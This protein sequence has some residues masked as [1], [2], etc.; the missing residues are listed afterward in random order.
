MSQVLGKPQL[1]DEDDDE[2]DELVGLADYG[3][4]PDSS[5][6]EP[7]SGAE[8]GGERQVPCLA[9]SSARPQPAS[10]PFP[11]FLPA[12]GRAERVG[13]GLGRDPGVRSCGVGVG[14]GAGA[15]TASCKMG[16]PGCS[17]DGVPGS[18][19]RAQRGNLVW[20]N[21]RSLAGYLP[22]PLIRVLGRIWGLRR[23][24]V[25][26]GSPWDRSLKAA[27]KAGVRCRV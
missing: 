13:R 12:P 3:D 17:G 4:R 21:M 5:D 27:V 25:P 6:A 26:P 24:G 15:A 10:R 11:L 14:R 16:E 20:G 19:G 18:V 7:D 8:E 23:E 2:E 22:P 1:E 9:P